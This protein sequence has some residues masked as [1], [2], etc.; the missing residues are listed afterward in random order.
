MTSRPELFAA[1]EA[2]L[3]DSFHVDPVAG[4]EDPEWWR[5]KVEEFEFQGGL[6][7]CEVRVYALLCELDPEYDG[8][9][10]SRDIDQAATPDGLAWFSDSDCTLYARASVPFADAT[11]AQIERAIRDCVTVARSPAAT[12]L[13]ASHAYYG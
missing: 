6:H 3:R 11:P 5:F 7:T 10:V 13:I 8:D 4:R 9:V 1:F 12:G 2:V